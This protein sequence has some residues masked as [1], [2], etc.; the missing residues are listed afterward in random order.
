MT[1]QRDAFEAEGRREEAPF[2]SGRS[3]PPELFTA[4]QAATY[5]HVSG[6]WLR[7][8]LRAR[9]FS[10]VKIAGRWYM[11]GDQ[12][13]EA[14]AAMTITALPVESPSPAGLARNSRFRRRIN[15]KG[16]NA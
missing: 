6:A 8:Q 7:Q 11:T 9:R 14:I 15:L 1:G 3:I 4:D 2:D 10:G 5:L 12:I 13:G 16:D